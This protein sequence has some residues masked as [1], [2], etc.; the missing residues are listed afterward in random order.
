VTDGG[1]IIG[2]IIYRRA[3][4]KKKNSKKGPITPITPIII[5]ETQV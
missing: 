3:N 1:Q 2:I 4:E 5:R